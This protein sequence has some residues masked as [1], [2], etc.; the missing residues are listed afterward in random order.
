MSESNEHL[1]AAQAPEAQKSA[2]LPMPV[3]DMT[4][5]SFT[6][7]EP[8]TQAESEQPGHSWSYTQLCLLSI[9]EQHNL[10]ANNRNVLKTVSDWKQCLIDSQTMA[11]CLRQSVHLQEAAVNIG[12]R[13]FVGVAGNN[14]LLGRRLLQAKLDCIEAVTIAR[15]PAPDSMPFLKFPAEIRRVIYYEYFQEVVSGARKGKPRIRHLKKSF[16]GCP[17][18]VSC[19]GN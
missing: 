11:R 3:A 5:G 10:D 17:C 8:D 16:C 19:V 13:M 9:P 18:Y 7:P 2:L 12:T 4:T 14:S 15:T 1:L 6:S